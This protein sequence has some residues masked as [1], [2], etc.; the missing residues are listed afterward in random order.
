MPTRNL[1]LNDHQ[2]GLMGRQV[3]SGRYQNASEVLR[4]GLRLLERREAEVAARLAALRQAVEI[5]VRNLDDER[6]DTLE[7]REDIS[8]YLNAI[9]AVKPGS[10]TRGL[11][12][13]DLRS[14]SDARF[15]GG[16]GLVEAGQ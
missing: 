12:L 10:G 8:A 16:E 13:A 14:Q 2:D 6:F 4:E 15:R 7:T 5:G 11:D 3:E 1:V 9:A